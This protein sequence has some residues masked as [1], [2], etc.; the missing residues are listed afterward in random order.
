MQQLKNFLSKREQ[1]QA[2]LRFAECEKSRLKA[3][4]MITLALLMTAAAGAWATN[5][6]TLAVGDVIKV[7]DTFTPTADG[8]FNGNG[9]DN[10]ETYTLI[11]AD[12]DNIYYVTEKTDGA[13]YVFK[14]DKDFNPYIHF[15]KAFA[16][17]AISDGLEVTK[18]ETVKGGMLSY[19]LAVHESSA[20]SATPVDLTRGTGEKI[21]EWTLTNGMPAGNVLLTVAYK[22][23][24]A[25]ALKYGE[26]AITDEANAVTAYKGF[27]KE[28]ADALNL[29]AAVKNIEPALSG[30]DAVAVTTTAADYIFESSDGNKIGFKTATKGIYDLTGTLDQM[31]FRDLTENSP[32]TL[33]V[34]YKGTADLESS[35]AFLRVTIEKKTYTVSLADN[36]EDADSWKGNVNDAQTDVN[37]PITKLDK[38]DAVTLKY[39][40]RLKVKN[41]TATTDAEP[42]P[43][44]VPLTI[45]AVTPGT[46]QVKIQGFNAQES[47]L[48]TGMKYSVNGGA[49]TLITKSTD[50]TVAKDDKVQFYGNGTSTQV[51]GGRTAVRIQGSGD[52]FQTKVYGNIMSLLDETGFATKTDLQNADEYVFNALFAENTTL[53][54]ASELLLPA[55]TLTFACYQQMFDSCTNLTK[56]PKLPATT[57]APYCYNLM[58]HYCTSLTSAY[59]KAAYTGGNNECND[60]F[61]DCK[62]TGAVLHTT[63]DSKASWQDK[64]GM[65]WYNWSVADDWQE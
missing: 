45:E 34:N 61:N 15:E 26:Q 41:V 50:I 9:V 59:V 53:I 11:R 32:V 40:G 46:I 47:T 55:A 3:K 19:T 49:K 24:T 56:A 63:P 62:A 42:D 30:G 43:L 10:G 57:L 35:M 6:T 25:M 5:Y 28:F 48:Q 27:E 33:T 20:T 14:F 17:T 64:M 52:G 36:T 21:N 23:R 54:D 51:Y 1:S 58:F 22:D 4:I 31:E 37:L 13:Y 29:D 16:V 60:M 65:D 39:K 12:V 2:R 38:G 8:A 44:T 18:I 7:G